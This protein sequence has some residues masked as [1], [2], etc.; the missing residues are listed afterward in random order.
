MPS[1]CPLLSGCSILPGGQRRQGALLLPRKAC[2]EHEDRVP[3]LRGCSTWLSVA[4]QHGLQQS[5]LPS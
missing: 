3:A 2:E 5:F 4:R 1:L